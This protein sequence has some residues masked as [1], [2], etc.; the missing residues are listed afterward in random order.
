MEL[1][2]RMFHISST[3]A[4][5]DFLQKSIEL[6]I[7]IMAWLELSSRSFQIFSTAAQTDFLQSIEKI[8]KCWSSVP[9]KSYFKFNW[10]SREISLGSC[11]GDLEDS[12]AQFH[13][14]PY[15]NSIDFWRKSVSAAVKEIWEL[16]ELSSFQ[17]LIQLQ[18]ISKGNLLAAVEKI[19]KLP[20]LN[21][22]QFRI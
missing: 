11:R 10:F 21:S 9:C 13:S 22:N 8:W 5:T 17:I 16:P 1:S 2:S 6:E 14:N 18:L 15:S 4:D 12:W 3:A 7:W 19:W 20:E